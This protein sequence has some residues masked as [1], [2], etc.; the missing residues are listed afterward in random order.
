ML[1]KEASEEN[2]VANGMAV[3]EDGE[4]LSRVSD[5]HELGR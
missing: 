3:L 1:V 5:Q 4:E 2:R